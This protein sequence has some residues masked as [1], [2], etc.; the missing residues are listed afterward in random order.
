MTPEIEW[1]IDLQRDV[2]DNIHNSQMKIIHVSIWMKEI[3]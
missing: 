2:I 3:S 1:K